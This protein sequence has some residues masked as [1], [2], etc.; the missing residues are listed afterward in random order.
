MFFPGDRGH[1]RGWTTRKD[2]D[3]NKEFEPYLS[4]FHGLNKK[5]GHT[6]IFSLGLHPFFEGSKESFPFLDAYP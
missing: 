5:V 4:L 6:E 1:G 2:H 3:S